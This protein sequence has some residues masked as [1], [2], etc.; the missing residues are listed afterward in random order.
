MDPAYLASFG[1]TE[2]N[3]WWFRARREIVVDQLRRSL[4]RD[5]IDLLDVGCGT[6]GTLAYFSAE[7]P[8]ARCRGI[9]PDPAARAR[10][11]DRGLDVLEG[12]ATPMPVASTSQDAVIALDV[13]EHIEHDEAAARELA[14][15][16]RPGGI[17]L[18]TVPAYMWM[19]GPHD[20][21]NHHRRRYVR[22]EVERLMSDADLE[23]EFSTYFNTLLFPLGVVQRAAE[24]VTGR[25]AATEKAPLTAINAALHAIFEMERPL[26]RRMQLP[27]GVSILVV[28]RKGPSGL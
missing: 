11:L 9:E 24:R 12:T 3:H 14:R 20:E 1:D 8:R 5:D 19:W 7:L 10:C 13:I 16:L 22:S 17:A 26:L 2:D 25:H 6:G 28:A 18:V 21:L 4:P 23:I 15:S 27:W